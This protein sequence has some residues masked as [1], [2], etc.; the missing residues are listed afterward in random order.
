MLSKKNQKLLKECIDHWFENLMML[1]LN[2]LSKHDNLTDDVHIYGDYCA[3]CY[4]YWNVDK[5]TCDGCPISE[6][7]GEQDCH[8]SPYYEVRKFYCG[9]YEDLY[10]AIANQLNFLMSLEECPYFSL[11]N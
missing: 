2:H 6:R 8:G 11:L 7:T 5:M 4:E 1:Q 3:F 10:K 9:S